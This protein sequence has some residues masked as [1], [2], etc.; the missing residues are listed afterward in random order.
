VSNQ[1]LDRCAGILLG[2]AAG[3]ALGAGY[4]FGTPPS[5]DASMKGGGLGGWEPGEW[6]DDT[7]MA[8]CIAEETATGTVKPVAMAVRFL[9]WYRS[10]P[11]DVGIQT[12]SVL[13]G[14]AE[15]NEVATRAADYFTSHPDH[16]A[17]N[18]S[19]MR[20]APL[21]LAGLGDDERLVELAMSVSALT[22]ADPV[23]G[24]ACALWCVAIDRAIR[25]GTLHGVRD[26][27]ELL[28]ADR[29]SYWEERLEEVEAG[30][31]SRFSPNGFVVSA[32]QAALAAIWHTPVPT[33]DEP[34][35]H[36]Q[37]ALQAAVQIG[38]DTDTVAAIAGSLLGARWGASAVPV[39]WRAMLHGQPG[40]YGPPDYTSQDL[41]RL[42]VMSARRGKPDSVGWPEAG[43]LTSYY[44]EDWSVAPVAQPLEEDPGVLLGNVFGAAEAS[45]DVTVSLCRMGRA[46]LDAVNHPVRVE[47]GL[48]D[49]GR[50]VNANLEFTFRDLA[51]AMVRWRNEGKTV[52]VHCVRAEHRTPAV[53]AAY[54]AEKSGLSGREALRRVCMQLPMAAVNPVFEEALERVWPNEVSR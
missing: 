22:H 15:A 25:Q 4:E 16:S 36:L 5:G 39:E 23:A 6:T 41:V 31:P 3:D 1:N 52:L 14:S 34:C 33:G 42:A 45:A 48:E 28:P 12:R 32:F 8:I 7:Q 53:G 10:G 26:G 54:L 20:T 18:G 21:A 9:E 49:V 35:L 17:G 11:A 46:Q 2:L 27:I 30:P 40:A 13:S 19:L 29:R 37:Q 24:E 47:L 51:Q 38:E 43:D 50:S 44:V